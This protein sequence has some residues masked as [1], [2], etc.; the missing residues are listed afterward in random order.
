M[1]CNAMFCR[2]KKFNRKV[3][4]LALCFIQILSKLYVHQINHLI[5]TVF[6][7]EPLAQPIDLLIIGPEPILFL[8]YELVFPIYNNILL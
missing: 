7:E 3:W 1:A 8:N 4:L 5:T 6:V 2:K